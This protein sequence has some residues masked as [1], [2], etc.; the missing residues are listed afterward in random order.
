MEIE[1]STKRAL[2]EV[3]K[4]KKIS[5]LYITNDGTNMPKGISQVTQSKKI[6]T[7]TGRVDYVNQGISVGLGVKEEKPKIVINL[8]SAKAEGSNFSAN[9]LKVC[10]VIN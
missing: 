4:E 6:L 5:V 7:I 3:A 9:L 2:D 1:F 10:K 8:S